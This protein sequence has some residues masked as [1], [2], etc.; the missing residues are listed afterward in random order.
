VVLVIRMTKMIIIKI[1]RELPE[2]DD[3]ELDNLFDLVLSE[4]VR[5][6]HSIP[7]MKAK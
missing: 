7:K 5:R 1:Q 3:K 6:R 4:Y 2:I